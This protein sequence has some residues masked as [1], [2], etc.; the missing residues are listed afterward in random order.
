MKFLYIAACL[1]FITGCTPAIP[2]EYL[3]KID[4]SATYPIVKSNIQ[5]YIGVTVA[6]GGYIQEVSNIPEGTYIEVIESPLDSGN[7]PEDL[8]QTRG[9]FLIGY[10]GYAEPV[11]YAK[12]RAITVVGEVQGYQERPLGEIRYGYPVIHRLYDRLWDPKTTSDI[13]LGIG[14]GAVF[15]H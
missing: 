4:R 2:M 3:S 12:G 8:D 9:R 15:T 7:R 6:W 13:H 14:V 1:I 10:P 5:K 11:R